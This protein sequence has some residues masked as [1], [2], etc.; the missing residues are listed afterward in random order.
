MKLKF[1]D[2]YIEEN[3][4]GELTC[5]GEVAVQSGIIMRKNNI[6][7]AIYKKALNQLVKNQVKKLCK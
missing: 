1:L 4:R 3:K 5:V 6:S 7:L 2:G